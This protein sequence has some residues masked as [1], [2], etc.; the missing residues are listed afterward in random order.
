MSLPFSVGFLLSD[1]VLR[2]RVASATASTS[3]GIF[4]GMMAKKKHQ[5]PCKSWE[6]RAGTIRA[7][8][9]G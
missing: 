8:M 2:P 3:G 6:F 1:R 4:S 9:S 7:K 5:N